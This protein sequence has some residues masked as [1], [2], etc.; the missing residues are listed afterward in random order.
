MRVVVTAVTGTLADR[1]AD[2]VGH[3]GN[4]APFDS[5][6]DDVGD[7][8]CLHL[9]EPWVDHQGFPWFVIPM[10]NEIVLCPGSEMAT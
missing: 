6:P 8:L 3:R 7:F 10:C 4:L 2:L 5:P 9:D 1:C